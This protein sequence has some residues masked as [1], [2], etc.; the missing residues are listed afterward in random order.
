MVHSLSPLELIRI[1]RGLAV[2][3]NRVRRL[4]GHGSHRLTITLDT[5]DEFLIGRHFSAVFARDSERGTESAHAEGPTNV[6]PAQVVR[7]CVAKNTSQY[8]AAIVDPP[9]QPG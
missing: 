7:R 1:H 5:G 3:A 9:L 4:V 6:G 2:N 8:R